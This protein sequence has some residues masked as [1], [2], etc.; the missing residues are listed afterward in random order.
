MSEL[1]KKN[2]FVSQTGNCICEAMNTTSVTQK[3]E[4]YRHKQHSQIKC[5]PLFHTA[6]Y[7]IA[8]ELML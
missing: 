1:L 8:H 3:Q 5:I 7:F 2:M 4:M 6:N